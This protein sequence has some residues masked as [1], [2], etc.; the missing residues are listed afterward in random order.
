MFPDSEIAKSYSQG[1]TKVKYVI[2]FGIAPYIKQLILD[3]I[4]GKPFF[5][6]FDENTTQQ[7]TKQFDTYLHNWSSENQISNIYA[8]S[9]VVGHCTSDQLFDH[10]H[11]F[12]KEL[13]LNPNLLLHLG[14]DGPMHR[15]SECKF[16]VSTGPCKIF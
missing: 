13:E 15:W 1:E 14:M 10:F 5:F 2:Q 12:I 9:C 11:H 6:L 3:D 16:E 4:K 8:G 7:V